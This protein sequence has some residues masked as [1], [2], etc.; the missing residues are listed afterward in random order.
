MFIKQTMK[1]PTLF[2]IIVLLCLSSIDVLAKAKNKKISRKLSSQVPDP[3]ISPEDSSNVT[4]KPPVSPTE[5]PANQNNGPV[6]FNPPDDPNDFKTETSLSE[7]LKP[8]PPHSPNGGFSVNV[9]NLNLAEEKPKPPHSPLRNSQD[10]PIPPQN[11]AGTGLLEEDDNT[12]PVPPHNPN[13]VGNPHI[14]KEDPP[15]PPHKPTRRFL[16]ANSEN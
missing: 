11:E 9:D 6:E 15:V 2:F 13:P 5:T 14:F 8:R 7:T 4:N 1:V 16:K 12:I 10:P 3:P